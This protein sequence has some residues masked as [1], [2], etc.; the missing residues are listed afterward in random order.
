M[1][2]ETG[3]KY[4]GPERRL[5]RQSELLGIHARLREGDS[6]MSEFRESLLANTE[7]TKLTA[8]TVSRIDENTAG[9]IAFSNDLVSGTK[10]LCRCAK[11]VQWAGEMVRR[12]WFVLFA[13]AAAYAYTTNQVKLLEFL[14]SLAKP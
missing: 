14:V 6:V 10:F 9:F 3:E 4:V 13:G 12:N 11:G 5:E 2:F 7:L 8:A 1:G